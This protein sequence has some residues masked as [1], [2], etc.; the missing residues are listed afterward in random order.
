MPLTGIEKAG[1][2]VGF[3][4]KVSNSDLGKLSLRGFNRLLQHCLISMTLMLLDAVSEALDPD[5]HE[6]SFKRKQKFNYRN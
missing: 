1:K 2:E 5:L 3:R 6:V 4:G